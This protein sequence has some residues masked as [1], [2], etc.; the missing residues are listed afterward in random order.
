MKVEYN[1]KF[2]ELFVSEAN[3]LKPWKIGTIFVLLNNLFL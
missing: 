3:G 2:E 1:E